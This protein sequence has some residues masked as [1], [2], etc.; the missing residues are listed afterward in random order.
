[1]IQ[2][3]MMAEQRCAWERKET[4]RLWKEETVSSHEV[5]ARLTQDVACLNDPLI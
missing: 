3:L 5:I 4:A 1:M 2:N